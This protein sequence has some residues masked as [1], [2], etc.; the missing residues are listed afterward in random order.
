MQ[1]PT[2]RGSRSPR[3]SNGFDDDW[4]VDD[5]DLYNCQGASLCSKPLNFIP[6]DI[7]DFSNA[8]DGWFAV[9]DNLDDLKA[10]FLEWV[11][12]DSYSCLHN[13]IDNKCFFP[14]T[15]KRGNSSYSRKQIKKFAPIMEAF[16]SQR[17]SVQINSRKALA[18]SRALLVTFTFSHDDW[19][20]GDAWK[21]ITKAVNKFR[22]Y[23]TKLTGLTYGA[24]LSKK[25]SDSGYPAPHLL[26]ILDKPITTFRKWSA[27]ERQYVWRIQSLAVVDALRKAWSRYSRGSFCD[28]RAVVDGKVRNRNAM[29]YVLKYALKTV[30][31]KGG[32]SDNTSIYTHAFQK[33]YNLRNHV[34]KD[35]LDRIEY[36]PNYTR[37]DRIRNELKLANRQ[38]DRI[39][40]QM[41]EISE[42]PNFS[43]P[44]S[45]RKEELW[46]LNQRI[47]DLERL[48]QEVK[49]TDCPWWFI[50]GGFRDL[51]DAMSF[52]SDYISR[53]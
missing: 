26:I 12:D 7:K 48:V 31:T 24:F 18:L 2:L 3:M 37:L 51:A 35:F 42:Y 6:T 40:N 46:M 34:S 27:T 9:P 21:S 16:K 1:S 38:R 52:Y 10:S 11:K 13:P 53:L 5:H 22:A 30:V 17:F 45:G 14:L 33:I 43:I 25:S 41:K 19:H 36:S 20:H 44:A 29:S 32:L 4:W 15:A 8:P 50:G 28:I 39:I 49:L 23:F 47:K